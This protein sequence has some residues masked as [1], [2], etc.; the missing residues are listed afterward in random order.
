MYIKTKKRGP[1]CLL[2][3]DFE[4]H[5]LTALKIVKYCS[6]VRVYWK[7]HQDISCL[8]IFL[9]VHT[10][11]IMVNDVISGAPILMGSLSLVQHVL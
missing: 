11:K 4:K 8:F 6:F 2:V 10:D 3:T 9:H 5:Y 7:V 1:L